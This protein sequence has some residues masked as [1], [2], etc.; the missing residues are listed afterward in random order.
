MLSSLPPPPCA[1]MYGDDYG[2]S[3]AALEATAAAPAL[4]A[5]VLSTAIVP[6][7]VAVQAASVTNTFGTTAATPLVMW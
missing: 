4:P 3:R 2:F 7:T 6:A 1:G 5:A